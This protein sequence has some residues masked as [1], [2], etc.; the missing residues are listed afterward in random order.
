MIDFEKLKAFYKLG[1]NLSLS[2]VQVLIKAASRRSYPAGEYIIQE[3]SIK[4]EVFFIR[5]GL[6]RA[7]AVNDKGDEITTALRIEHQLFVSPNIVLFNRP[8]RFYFQALEDTDVFCIDYNLMQ[9][10]IDNNP[11]LES[12]RKF[13]FQNIMRQALL[14]IDSFVMLNPE[15]RY[16]DFIKNNPDLVNRVPDKYI[17]NVLGIT[18]VSLSRIRKRIASRR[19]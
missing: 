2:D 1:R 13:I 4:A 5:T 17:A 10:I 15:E 7:F 14:R 16:L 18:P 9:T 19:K 12:N 3:G 11:K 6:V 8:S